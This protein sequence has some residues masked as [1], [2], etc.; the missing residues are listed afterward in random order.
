MISRVYKI[1]VSDLLFKRLVLL[2]VMQKENHRVIK[3][4]HRLW[5]TKPE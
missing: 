5:L 3:V 1:K 4:N 2:F